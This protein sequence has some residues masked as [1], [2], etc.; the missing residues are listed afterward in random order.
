[1]PRKIERIKITRKKDPGGGS[2]SPIIQSPPPEPVPQEPTP[3]EPTP[4]EPTPEKPTPDKTVPEKPTPQEPVPQEPTPEEKLLAL[5]DSKDEDYIIDFIYHCMINMKNR[6]EE[7]M[8][9]DPVM[10]AL[11]MELKELIDP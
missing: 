9:D 5:L 6:K 1:M 3:E 10:W 8:R 11:I 4:E 7:I 2:G